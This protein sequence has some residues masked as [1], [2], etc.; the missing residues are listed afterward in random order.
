M[1]LAT[2]RVYTQQ[3]VTSWITI[4]ALSFAAVVTIDMLTY[5]EQSELDHEKLRVVKVFEILFL[6]CLK[7][8]YICL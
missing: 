6:R 5:I 7:W 3:D 4:L 8:L 1:D 2:G